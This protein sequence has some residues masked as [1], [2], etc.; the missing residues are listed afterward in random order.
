[1]VAAGPVV[2]ASPRPRGEVG[3]AYAY[4]YTGHGWDRSVQLVGLGGSPAGG[5]FLDQ[6]TGAIT[7]VPTTAGTG[8]FTVRVVDAQN[9]AATRASSI[10]VVAAPSL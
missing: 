6:N 4:T 3:V 7:G 2:V 5:L 1:M 10:V 9:Q 8:S